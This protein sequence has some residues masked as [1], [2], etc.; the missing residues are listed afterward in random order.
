MIWQSWGIVMSGVGLGLGTRA[1]LAFDHSVTSA[2]GFSCMEGIPLPAEAQCNILAQL[3]GVVAYTLVSRD[4][5]TARL[6]MI[7]RALGVVNHADKQAPQ[8]L[9]TIGLRVPSRGI[10]RFSWN[11]VQR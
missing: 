8:P 10:L 6:Y 9:F 3:Y 7:Q 2:V 11:L 1:Y 5:Y 4:S